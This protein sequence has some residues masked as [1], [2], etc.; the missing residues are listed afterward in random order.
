MRIIFCHLVRTQKAD[1]ISQ[2]EERYAKS[3]TRKRKHMG[4]RF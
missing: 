1:L 4:Q 3:A 2:M